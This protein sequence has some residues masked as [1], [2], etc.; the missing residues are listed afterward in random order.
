MS[1]QAPKTVSVDEAIQLQPM[2][3]AGRSIVGNFNLQVAL[4]KENPKT[5]SIA[6]YFFEGED[7]FSLSKRLDVAFAVAGRQEMKAKIEE[8]K[9]TVR[10][11]EEART[12]IAIMVEELGAKPKLSSQEK[13]TLNTQQA[14]L[15]HLAAK[16]ETTKSAIEQ[17]VKSV[18]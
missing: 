11:A 4:G 14:N 16:V 9:A 3:S 17:A 2:D 18:A 15:K 13:M 5:L 6:G 10:Q 8:M 12:Q 1:E 7:E